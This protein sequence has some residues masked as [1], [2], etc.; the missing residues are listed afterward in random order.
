MSDAFV[1]KYSREGTPLWFRQFGSPDED[2][3]LSIE[4]G[5]GGTDN[6]YLTG[7][8]NDVMSVGSTVLTSAGM[9]D[10]FLGKLSPGGD[11]LW[12][13]RF[14]GTLND[15]GYGITVDH[16]DNVIVAGWFADTIDFGG[17]ISI[18]SY[19]GSDMFVANLILR[20]PASGLNT[21]E[22]RGWI[23]AT[24]WIAAKRAIYM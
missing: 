6:C 21:L 10:V 19:G 11:V 7:Y 15:I 24:R 3:C 14:G 8:F 5:T 16:E 17:G 20:E 2:V 9:W 18:S 13:K 23:T 12:L 22:T 1:A 4:A